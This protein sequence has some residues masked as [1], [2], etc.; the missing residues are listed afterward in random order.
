MGPYCGRNVPVRVVLI[1]TEVFRAEEMADVHDDDDDGGDGDHANDRAG[2][3][4]RLVV[5]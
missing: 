5:L 3:T 1:R 2:K 4:S